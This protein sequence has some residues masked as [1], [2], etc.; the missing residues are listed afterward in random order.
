MSFRHADSEAEGSSSES[1]EQDEGRPMVSNTTR[2]SM[3]DAAAFP[4]QDLRPH[5]CIIGG[6]KDGKQVLEV[7]NAQFVVISTIPCC[8]LSITYFKKPPQSKFSPDD[9][10]SSSRAPFQRYQLYE[11]GKHLLKN[12][13]TI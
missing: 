11:M 3:L 10:S 4:D 9:E 2:G 7:S 5:I 1:L 8:V 6:E 13:Q 12:L